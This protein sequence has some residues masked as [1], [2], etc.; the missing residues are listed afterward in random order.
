MDAYIFD[1]DVDICD[2]VDDAAGGVDAM[3]QD[4]MDQGIIYMPP[5]VV[6]LL[7]PYGIA[8]GVK[9][10]I[11]RGSYGWA[12][13][14]VDGIDTQKDEQMALAEQMRGRLIGRFGWLWVRCYKVLG[15]ISRFTW[16]LYRGR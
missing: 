12:W 9:F 5:H 6:G 7:P 8:A 4:I 1:I 11:P 14:C 3:R 10:Y 2:M 13:Q 15:S 16:W